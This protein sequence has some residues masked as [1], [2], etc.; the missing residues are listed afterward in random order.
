MLGKHRELMQP[1]IDK[2]LTWGYYPV[3]I[4][5]KFEI[6]L[7]QPRKE[8]N[9]MEKPDLSVVTP[10]NWDRLGVLEG[11]VNELPKQDYRLG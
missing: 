6:L 1:Q 8:D 4:F 2:M 10:S 9:L 5:S 11:S 3:Q 7:E